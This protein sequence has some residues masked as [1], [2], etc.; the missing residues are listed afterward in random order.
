MVGM[1]MVTMIIPS[2]LEMGAARSS[3]T[4]FITKRLFWFA[5]AY[6]ESDHF[7]DINLRTAISTGPGYQIIDRGDYD[8]PWLKDLTLY[9]EAG[10]SYFDEDFRPLLTTRPSAAG[11]SQTELAD[12]G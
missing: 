8:S 3:S 1:S 2:M 6:F 5:S 4:I 7:Q 10:P 11:G 9:A 12:V